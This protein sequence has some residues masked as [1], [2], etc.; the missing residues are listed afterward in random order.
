[1]RIVLRNE[2]RGRRDAPYVLDAVGFGNR[3]NQESEYWLT[4][5]WG[6]WEKFRPDDLDGLQRQEKYRGR[7]KGTLMDTVQK[8]V[9]EEMGEGYQVIE[10]V[11]RLPEWPILPHGQNWRGG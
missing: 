1:M 2:G 6:R 7:S 11:S 10:E 9:A 5:Y 3:V 4:A 8:L